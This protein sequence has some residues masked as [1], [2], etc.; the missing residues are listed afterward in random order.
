MKVRQKVLRSSVVWIGVLCWASVVVLSL[1]V[2][3]GEKILGQSPSVSE[4][5]DPKSEKVDP[6]SEK[7][8]PKSEKI[9]PKSEKIDPKSEKI[10]P[11]SEKVD[12]KS[13]KIDPKSE[14]ID[15]KSEKIDPK[16]EKIDPK[17][18]KIDPKSEKVD[19][20]SEKVDPKQKPVKPVPYIPPA[21]KHPP[22]FK[23]GQLYKPPKKQPMHPTKKQIL[24][25]KTKAQAKEKLSLAHPSRTS[26]PQPVPPQSFKNASKWKKMKSELKK[27]WA[28]KAKA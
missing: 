26:S 19:P 10:D 4:K 17:S 6:K 27:S 5:V 8:D 18:E 7:I 22:K 11:K 16:S 24:A 13:E 25:L 21:P 12:P 23:N 14:K 1:E 28:R 15:P 2:Q 3:S 9:D 20:K